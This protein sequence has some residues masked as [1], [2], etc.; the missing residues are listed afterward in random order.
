MTHPDR[1]NLDLTVLLG[2]P[3][4]DPGCVA[5]F[6]AMDRIVDAQV[7]GE[8][9]TRRHPDVARHLRNC[10]ACRDDLDALHRAIAE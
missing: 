1:P 3:G 9:W 6:D 7:A 8:D 10:V 4:H 2:E 5:A